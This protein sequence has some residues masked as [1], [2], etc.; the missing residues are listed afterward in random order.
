MASRPGVWVETSATTTD[1][2]VTPA[3]RRGL[4]SRSASDSIGLCLSSLLCL[5]RRK[6]KD[7]VRV[8]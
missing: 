2:S 6:M 1:G 5:T 8:C 7:F 4:N 3:P